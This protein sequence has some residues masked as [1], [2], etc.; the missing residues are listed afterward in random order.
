LSEYEENRAEVRGDRWDWNDGWTVMM[1]LEIDGEKAD[2]WGVWANA[3][4]AVR[5]MDDIMVVG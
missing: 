5:E 1:W 2:S 4:K 3:R